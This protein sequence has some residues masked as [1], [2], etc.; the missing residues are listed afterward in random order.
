MLP[1]DAASSPGAKILAVCPALQ[2]ESD[3]GRAWVITNEGT[4][5]CRNA[6]Y[7]VARDMDVPSRC[8]LRVLGSSVMVSERAGWFPSAAETRGWVS[9]TD[10]RRTDVQ[11]YAAS[12]RSVDLAARFPCHLRRP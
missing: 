11:D 8:P 1:Q 4:W 5:T 10:A 3:V 2:E 9:L 7:A 6:S 12:R